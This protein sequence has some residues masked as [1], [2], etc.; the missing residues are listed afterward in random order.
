MRWGVVHNAIH[1]T[2]KL[3]STWN[4]KSHQAY[5][6]SSTIIGSTDRSNRSNHPTRDALMSPDPWDSE[7]SSFS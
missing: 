2:E 4:P 5:A 7:P 6:M 1:S 3:F